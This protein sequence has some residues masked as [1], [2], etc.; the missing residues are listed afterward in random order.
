MLRGS[1]KG[2]ILWGREKMGCVL[3]PVGIFL[4]IRLLVSLNPKCFSRCLF[5]FGVQVT[6][7][8]HIHLMLLP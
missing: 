5:S 7:A 1:S 3:I 6:D 2:K 4:C 8:T